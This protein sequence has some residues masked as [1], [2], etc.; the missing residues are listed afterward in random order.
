M[1]PFVRKIVGILCILIGIIAFVTPLTPGA[2][3]VFVGLELLGFHV[4][5]GR[6]IL[7]TWL[8]QRLEKW[9]SDNEE[10]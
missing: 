1:K 4:L 2:W 6:K 10:K 5:G 8:D 3:L 9:F 7:P